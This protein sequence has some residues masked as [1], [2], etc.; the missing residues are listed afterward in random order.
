MYQ[1]YKI[2]RKKINKKGKRS[3]PY[4]LLKNIKQLR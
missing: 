3:V 4:I 1:N 2:I